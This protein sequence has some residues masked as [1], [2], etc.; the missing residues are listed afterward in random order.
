[1]V[2]F[3]YG[4]RWTNLSSPPA[5]AAARPALPPADGQRVQ[6]RPR[7]AYSNGCRGSGRSRPIPSRA[8]VHRRVDRGPGHCRARGDRRRG[9]HPC[10]LGNIVLRA[11]RPDC[12]L[13]LIESED[14]S[15]QPVDYKRGRAPARTSRR[16]G[17]RAGPALRPGAH[18]RGQ[19]LSLQRRRALFPRKP[20]TRPRPL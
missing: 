8:R 12:Q 4:A 19:R 13:D 18:T 6:Y 11:A 9:S 2:R 1:M 17:A 3:P 5:P 10:A 16:L 7:L 14:G 15:L 20:R